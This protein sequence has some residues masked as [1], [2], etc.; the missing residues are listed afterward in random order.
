MSGVPVA[1]QEQN[2]Y[3]GFTTRMLARWAGQV[4]LAFPEA[5]AHL[6]PGRATEIIHNGNPIRPPDPTID[7]E[8]ARRLFGLG[9]GP[10]VLVVGGSQGSRAINEAL[11]N[12]LRG[13]AAG[14]L[15]AAARPAPTRG[16]DLALPT[17]D[18]RR[19][20]SRSSA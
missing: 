20:L 10:V 19:A 4:H 1:L 7:R 8:A 14:R 18:R 9:E 16:R 11:L 15:E 17:S 2:S 6:K 12:E 3:P 13:V 5:A